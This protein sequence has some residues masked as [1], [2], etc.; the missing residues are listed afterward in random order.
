MTISRRVPGQ[1]SSVESAT[2]GSL[3]VNSLFRGTTSGNNTARRRAIEIMAYLLL[4]LMG[5]TV[6]SFYFG[7]VRKGTEYYL[8]PQFRGAFFVFMALGAIVA[9]AAHKESMAEDEVSQHIMPYSGSTKAIYTPP[10][11]GSQSRIWMFETPDSPQQIEAF[12]PRMEHRRGWEVIQDFP[13]LTLWKDDKEMVISAI[14]MRQT[15]LTYELREL[16]E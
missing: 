12:Y 11:P 2:E 3:T 13:F 10:V 5:L 8:L 14:A 6:V 7:F 4:I 1:P 9:F 16:K 15:I